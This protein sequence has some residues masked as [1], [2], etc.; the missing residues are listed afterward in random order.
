MPDHKILE[1][2]WQTSEV[3]F[4]LPT[5]NKRKLLPLSGS[6]WQKVTLI[7]TVSGYDS[8]TPQVPSS[9]ETYQLTSLALLCSAKAQEEK[10]KISK[11][12][13]KSLP[14][15]ELLP[16]VFAIRLCSIMRQK[17]SDIPVGVICWQDIR[18]EFVFHICCQWES[19]QIQ[20]CLQKSE[21]SSGNHNITLNW[22]SS[23]WPH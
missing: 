5:T 18:P 6:G 22:F 19:H 14:K 12:K 2:N 11:Q 16:Q 9:S 8:P 17:K 15:L 3:S 21:V 7:A 4:W 20:D 1:E 23:L 10:G 13:L